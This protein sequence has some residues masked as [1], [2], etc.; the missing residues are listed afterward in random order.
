MKEVIIYCDGAC[1]GN[2]GPGG[3]ACVLEYKG[4]R[5]ELSGFAED[6]TNNRMELTAALRGLLALKERCSVKVHTD[7]AY[8]HNA[9]DKGWIIAWQNNGWKTASKKPVEN[10]DLWKQLVN[11]SKNHVVKWY[12]VKGHA[13]DELNNLCDK[14]AREQIKKN[15]AGQKT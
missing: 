6:T 10:Q 5:K 2:P 9:F 1:S 15:V 4:N 3:W 13:D 11:A 14:L 7:S 12:K 8:I